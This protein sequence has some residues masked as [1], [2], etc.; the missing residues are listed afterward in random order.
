LYSNASLYIY[1]DYSLV[2][3]YIPKYSRCQILPVS[4]RCS[5]VV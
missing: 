3:Q 5:G 2:C 4:A 1:R